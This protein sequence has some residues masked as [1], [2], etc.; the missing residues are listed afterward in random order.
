VS[1]WREL[2]L[3]LDAWSAVRRP[4]TMWCRDDDA[5]HDSPGIRR[6]LEIGHAARAPIA[7]A[8]IPAAL[9]PDL[10]AVLAHSAIASVVQHGYAHRNHAPPGERNRELG[11]HRP[12]EATLAELER[13]FAILR[14]NFGGRFVP[15][16]VPPWNRIDAS[17]V[18]RLPNA[19]FRGLSTIGPRATASP[20]PGI[21]QSNAHVD[22]I[23]WRR[24]RSF[25]GTDVAIDLLVRHL[26]ARRDGGVDASEPTGILSHHLD[27]NAAGWEFLAELMV[28]TRERGVAWLDVDAIFGRGAAAP[29]TSARS[30]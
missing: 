1:A 26:H 18:A 17:V 19:G 12:L 14:S 23:D 2:D 4:V 22:L 6:L 8:V 3:E 15:V 13:G 28:R 24:G 29:V 9:E 7:L 11:N 21:L 16:L 25:I 5:C 30:T 20:G 27:M 10:V